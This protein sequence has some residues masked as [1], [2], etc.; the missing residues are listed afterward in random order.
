MLRTAPHRVSGL[1]LALACTAACTANSEDVRPDP[2]DLFFPTGLAVS[3]D[4]RYLFVTSA[5]SELRYDSGSLSVIDLEIVDQIATA[6]T[7]RA[8]GYVPPTGCAVDPDDRETLVCDDGGDPAPRFILGDAGVRIGNFTSALGVQELSP[9]AVRV[10]ATVRG[11]PSV[12]YADWDGTKLNCAAEQGF[13]LCDDDH[14]LTTLRDLEDFTLEDEPYQ[15]FVDSTNE[16]AAIS[17]LTSG[18]ITLMDSPRDGAAVL[19]DTLIN[20]FNPTVTGVRGAAA[21]AGRDAS[22]AGEDLIYLA[23]RTE[24]RVHMMTVTDGPFG[25]MFVPSNFFFLNGVGNGAGNGSN[26]TGGSADTRGMVFDEGGDRM[27]L[28]NRSPASLQVYDTSLDATG[29]PRNRFLTATD[30]CTNASTMAM[31]DVGDG[32]RVFVTCYF[33]GDVYVV[34]PFPS[35]HV[36]AIITAGRGPYGVT[37]SIVRQKLYITNFLE[38]TIAV[39]ELD[40]TSPLRYEVILRIGVRR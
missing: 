25:K 11:D 33:S 8:D 4:Q 18:T 9:T 14:R 26:G 30:I 7:G 13:P 38:D 23:G 39:A 24:D 3:P 37:A 31:A 6:W 34:D 21:V 29:F 12:T 16:F 40:P 35:P 32:T 20:L 15:I 27:Y 2:E 5:N 28:V 19:T 1:A 22:G 10:I 36:E 17:H